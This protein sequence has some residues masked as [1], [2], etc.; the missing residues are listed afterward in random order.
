[1]KIIIALFGLL[2]ILAL[3]I[4]YFQ[5][6]GF[7]LLSGQNATAKIKDTQFKV[8]VANTPKEKETGLSGKNSLPK[9]QGMLF[10]FDKTDYYSFWM[11]NMKFSIDIIFLEKNKIV[12]IH[13]N[14]QPPKSPDES[15]SIY[16]P[17][18]PAD[19]VFEI[20]GGI[21]KEK[22]FQEGDTVTFTNL[23]TSK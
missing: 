9:D 16:K 1:M 15:L 3:G 19:M 23:K 21:S 12:T 4:T 20:N 7:S 10:L 13:H 14:V 17:S 18:A 22:N 6:G 11:K 5:K 2:L 8:Q